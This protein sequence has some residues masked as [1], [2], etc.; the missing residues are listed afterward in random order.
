MNKDTK[1]LLD[2]ISN[3]SIS[4]DFLSFYLLE[5]D[6][7]SMKYVRYSITCLLDLPDEILLLI[8]RYLSPYHVLYSFYT[9][10]NPEQR[11]HRMIFD[12]CTKIKLD[13]IKNNEYNYLSK[14]FSDSETPLRPKSL[15]LSNEHVTCLT[16]YYFTSIP[17]DVIHSMFANLKHLTLTDC[18][19]SDLQYLNKYIRNPTQLQYLHITIRKPDVNQG[20]SIKKILSKR[21]HNLDLI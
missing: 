12:Y 15:I 9:P 4:N 2:D 3:L 14:L 17:E 5:F 16:Y 11:L 19:E 10:S 20:M 6:S 8:C 1:R 18:S 13:G 7:S 21:E